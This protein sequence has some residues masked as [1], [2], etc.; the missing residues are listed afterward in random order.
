MPVYEYECG[1]CHFR[2]DRRQ[3]FDEEP[4]SICPNCQGKARRVIHAVP[5]H[6]KGRGFYS[7]DNRGGAA[8][9]PVDEKPSHTEE[10]K[11][12]AKAAA[13]AMS[14]SSEK[15]ESPSSTGS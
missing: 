13:S 11:E 3:H 2:F 4:V 15:N 6:F 10:E 12:E 14:D 1:N 9:R 8:S 7:T 5:V